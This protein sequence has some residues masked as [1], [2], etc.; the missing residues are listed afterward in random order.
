[1]PCS[2]IQAVY[3]KSLQRQL[4]Y[5]A[6]LIEKLKSRFI[7]L[8]GNEI[9]ANPF[10]PFQFDAEFATVRKQVEDQSRL[11]AKAVKVTAAIAYKVDNCEPGVLTVSQKYAI[12]LEPRVKRSLFENARL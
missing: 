6:A 10:R 4:T 8:Y 11:Q 7:E 3:Q 5:I 2:L 9:K 1:M 12:W